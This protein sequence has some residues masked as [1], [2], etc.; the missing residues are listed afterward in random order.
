MFTTCLQHENVKLSSWQA[1]STDIDSK[2]TCILASLF[3]VHDA[4]W[5]AEASQSV[6]LRTLTPY[7]RC[8]CHCGACSNSLGSL[9]TASF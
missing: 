9:T 1:P 6:I 7:Q 3:Y 2:Q 8:C 5:I 4:T